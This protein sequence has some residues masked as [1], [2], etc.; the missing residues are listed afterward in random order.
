MGNN[1][2]CTWQAA[3]EQL[4]EISFNEM[5]DEKKVKGKVIISFLYVNLFRQKLKDL[6][7][8][9]NG[10]ISVQKLFKL[11]PSNDLKEE[12][13]KRS[14]KTLINDCNEVLATCKLNEFD[15]HLDEER[16]LEL[17]ITDLVN[18]YTY[19]ISKNLEALQKLIFGNEKMT[20]TEDLNMLISLE[21]NKI[22][23]YE[24]NIR[25]SKILMN[26]ISM[27][28]RD[29]L[30]L[31]LKRF[32]NKFLFLRIMSNMGCLRTLDH[33]VII[34]REQI[35][36]ILQNA[37]NL[38][39]QK[40]EDII[41]ENYGDVL[42]HVRFNLTEEDKED[43]FTYDKHEAVE[44]NKLGLKSNRF[45]KRNSV[46][47][48]SPITKKITNHGLN[49]MNK[50]VVSQQ[51]SPIGG[52]RKSAL[53]G[54]LLKGSQPISPDQ[55]YLGPPVTFPSA[56]VT[57]NKKKQKTLIEVQKRVD[58]YKGEYDDHNFIYNGMGSLTDRDTFIYEGTFRMGKKHGFG[59]EF[60]LP[61][62]SDFKIY[63]RGEWENNLEEG[64]GLLVKSD[65]GVRIIQEGIFEKG[66]FKHGKQIKIDEIDSNFYIME[67]YIGLIV[68]NMYQ[69]EGT[70]KRKNIRIPI[71]GDRVEIEQEYEY[72][73]QFEK[74]KENG[75][76]IAKK[77][78]YV[79]GYNYKYQGEFVDG[80]MHGHGQVEFEG[81]YYIKNYDGFLQQDKWCCYYGRVEFKSGDIYEG[82]FD[83]NHGKFGIGLYF[84]NDKKQVERKYNRS[85]HFFGEY[86][87]DKKHG[88][89]KFLILGHQLLIGKY[90][91]GEKNGNFC[92]IQED[93]EE[94]KM[95]HTFGIRKISD[96]N[97]SDMSLIKQLKT[98]Y[99]FEND[100]G[101][102]KSDKP[103]KD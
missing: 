38:M 85:D 27:E 10:S 101:I 6:H 37:K 14:F 16:N 72:E 15:Y 67:Y 93:E 44:K 45:Q 3:V 64:C 13:L 66:V 29:S 63:Y 80:L 33:Y 103:F 9:I 87:N 35:Q 61:D 40:S 88:L 65:K 23:D 7:K 31:N 34:D 57:R 49:M 83:N 25:N 81:E 12:S 60:K 69:G 30:P 46:F 58:I 52:F 70:L 102:D 90:D 97:N 68:D 89:G 51:N 53:A 42:K 55:F 5:T 36:C 96:K 18:Y 19:E 20:N 4:T 71:Y 91:D 82:F 50:M 1:I 99:L 26:Y 84:H 100:E 74:N 43:I 86:K 47:H 54:N 8:D 21:I 22:F 95:K 17:T 41:A 92:L 77:K 2:K 78:L 24:E 76:G 11:P 59:Y 75:K 94:I 73:G 39:K 98:Y 79:L 32:I 56:L 62:N 28:N 48:H